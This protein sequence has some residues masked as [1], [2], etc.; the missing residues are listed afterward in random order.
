MVSPHEL[1]GEG[2]VF[3]SQKFFEGGWSPYGG[4]A[5]IGYEEGGFNFKK[6]NCILAFSFSQFSKIT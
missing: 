4:I 1:L 3:A 2:G 6:L 5:K